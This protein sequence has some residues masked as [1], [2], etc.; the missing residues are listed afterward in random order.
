MSD[1]ASWIT[2]GQKRVDRH[3]EKAGLENVAENGT[4]NANRHEVR[5]DGY[6][7]RVTNGIV[8]LYW[9]VMFIGTHIPNPETIIGPEVSDKLLHFSAYFVLMAM[10]VGRVRLL[11]SQWPAFGNL[12]RW[13]LLVTVYA[14]LDELLQAVP[15]INRHADLHDA[16]ADV[17]GA[18]TAATIAFLYGSL[19]GRSTSRCL[20]PTAEEQSRNGAK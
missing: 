3:Q 6:R 16:L 17:A 19:A 15:G 2:D 12:L 5:A 4:V 14:T 11:S 13:L 20:D 7:H 9:S 18:F 1:A 8:A 10:L